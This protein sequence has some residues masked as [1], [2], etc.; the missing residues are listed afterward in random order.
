M[1][2]D[3]IKD[4]KQCIKRLFFAEDMLDL[5][6]LTAGKDKNFFKSL[7]L[8]NLKPDYNHPIIHYDENERECFTYICGVPLQLPED[9]THYTAHE[10][11]NMIKYQRNN[12]R[13]MAGMVD[14]SRWLGEQNYLCY[15]PRQRKYWTGRLID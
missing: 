6:L 8:V 7:D 11:R 9:F 3:Y 13:Y 12:L 10:V 2:K 14:K 5:F 15:V 1:M 4:L